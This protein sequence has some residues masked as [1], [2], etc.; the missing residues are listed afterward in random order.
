MSWALLQY[1][2]GVMKFFTGKTGYEPLLSGEQGIFCSLMVL[3]EGEYHKVAE[4]NTMELRISTFEKKLQCRKSIPEIEP[5]R[6][7]TELRCDC[8]ISDYRLYSEY[9]FDSE[10][11]DARKRPSS[12]E[13]RDIEIRF[14]QEGS[15]KIMHIIIKGIV[16]KH[17]PLLKTECKGLRIK[18][19]DIRIQIGFD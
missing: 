1:V 13:L 3:Y 2:S 5:G 6:A 18:C 14:S 9:L 4:L 17:P 16:E 7:T 8:T 19:E 10:E 12:P 11:V 15:G